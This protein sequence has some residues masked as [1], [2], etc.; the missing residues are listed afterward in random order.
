MVRKIV[1]ALSVLSICNYTYSFY[2]VMDDLLFTYKFQNIFII[3]MCSVFTFL[4]F[5]SKNKEIL[6]LLSCYYS[7]FRKARVSNKC[8]YELLF[9]FV[10]IS[11]AHY[12]MSGLLFKLAFDILS[13]IIP[14][15]L[16]LT[17]DAY[18]YI[19]FSANCFLFILCSMP[20]IY[21]FYN[22]KDGVGLI[23]EMRKDA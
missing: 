20:I 3:L 22:L 5:A 11:Y 7:I 8:T 23:A 10:F 4:L 16:Y 17:V 2:T 13:R 19:F 21:M 9:C 1:L 12:Y 14:V 15:D 18:T 6:A